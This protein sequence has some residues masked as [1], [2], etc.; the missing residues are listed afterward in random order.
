M[1]STYG[2]GNGD[3]A[4]YVPGTSAMVTPEFNQHLTPEMPNADHARTNQRRSGSRYGCRK[5]VD[6]TCQ[7]SSVARNARSGTP[8][9][10]AFAA[11][12]PTTKPPS[13]AE[14]KTAIA[15]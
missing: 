10:S 9:P 13:D 8:S 3:V 12:Q 5:T 11:R 2:S 6:T 15:T 1:S 7:T 4:R 14:P